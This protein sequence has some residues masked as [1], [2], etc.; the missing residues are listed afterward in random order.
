MSVKRE[1][2]FHGDEVEGSPR[3]WLLSAFHLG[4]LRPISASLC[5][6]YR[7]GNKSAEADTHTTQPAQQHPALQHRRHK[8]WNLDLLSSLSPQRQTYRHLPAQSL[9]VGRLSATSSHLLRYS[10]LWRCPASEMPC[11]HD[12]PP[13]KWP[14]LRDSPPPKTLQIGRAHV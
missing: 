11:P 13:P 10:R 12:V 8:R 5:L 14:G 6:V 4:D 9:P 2:R 1:S 3:P 7:P